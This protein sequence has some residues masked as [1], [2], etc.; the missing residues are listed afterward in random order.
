MTSETNVLKD[1]I[2]GLE[3]K[4][5]DLNE[6]VL[7]IDEKCSQIINEKNQLM[8]EKENLEI[9]TN[10][11][12]LRKFMID[13]N[14]QLFVSTIGN[15][16]RNLTVDEVRNLGDKEYIQKNIKLDLAKN[17]KGELLHT[18]LL[19]KNFRIVPRNNQEKFFKINKEVKSDGKFYKAIIDGKN[20]EIDLNPK[21]SADGKKIVWPIKTIWKGIESE[22]PWFIIYHTVPNIDINEAAINDIKAKILDLNK[23]QLENEERIK[24]SKR[25]YV[26]IESKLREHKNDLEK[27][28]QK[29]SKKKYKCCETE[30]SYLRKIKVEELQAFCKLKKNLNRHFDNFK[31]ENKKDKDEDNRAVGEGINLKQE[32]KFVALLIYN[33]L[34]MLKNLFE[35]CKSLSYDSESQSQQI[36]NQSLLS[37]RKYMSF[38]NENISNIKREIFHELEIEVD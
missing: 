16:S 32:R 34:E 27:K 31:E 13:P 22:I 15:E 14:D 17:Y 3:I 33:H 21:A 26:E 8:K 28:E 37:A 7:Q 23:S 25:K 12:E 11:V 5:L 4:L 36:R 18:V 35:F 29:L 30:L 2:K 1:I 19:D 10:T 24:R 20:F 38:Y 6:K 9:G